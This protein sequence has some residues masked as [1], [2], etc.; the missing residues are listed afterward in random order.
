MRGADG[1]RGAAGFG[2]EDRRRVEHNIDRIEDRL[3]DAPDGLH[4]FGEPADPAALA[5]SELPPAA[6]LLWAQW[7]GLE[8]A[9][10]TL[11][12]WPLAELARV[13]A[14]LRASE[15]IAKDD[16][17]I[18]E[19]DG[20]VLVLCADPHAEGADVVLVEEDGERLP[21]SAGVDLLVLALL[22]EVAV[23]HDE[24]GEFQEQLFG[25]DGE[26]T[27]A[28]ERRLLRR[29]L[30]LDPDA[31]LARFRLAQSLRRAGELRAAAGE[32]RQLLRRAPDFAWGHHEQGRV[33]LGL[34]AGAE[35]CRAF[36]R[37]AELAREPGL[38]AHFLAW[39]CLAIDPAAAPGGEPAAVPKDSPEATGSKAVS[40]DRR[41]RPE[42]EK[43]SR[44]GLAAQVLA[45]SPEFVRAQEAALREALEKDDLVHADE[46]LRLGLA[47]VPGHL[48]LLSLR[49][50]LEAL[51]A[52]PPAADE[53]EEDDPLAEETDREIRAAWAAAEADDDLADRD[54]PAHKRP[55]DASKRAAGGSGKGGNRPP[56]RT[57]ASAGA[58]ASTPGANKPGANK[59]GVNK[60][61]VNKPGASK[62]NARPSGARPAAGKP[63]A[64]PTGKPEARP[65]GKPGA[66]PPGKPGARPT[67]KPG[68]RPP[69]KPA[70]GRG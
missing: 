57:G 52:Q 12:L 26:L 1:L 50:A 2:A 68:P 34:G 65:T 49:P 29:H 43:P 64:R 16:L 55:P 3:R 36:T 61:G 14:E 62:P 69:G 47:V 23:L 11:T 25:A 51:R 41:P 70:K 66:R 33:Q 31:P 42:A 60:P 10:G 54:A 35:A 27:R 21:H 56:T 8:L 67:G 22:G 24:E 28:A 9:A 48:G 59:P 18:G 58:R 37:A 32:L 30:D 19:R 7:D 53:A 20:A 63:G 6:R 38:Q 13:T 45:R 44:A 39:A 40:K 15:R 46:A 4:V 5:A 17:P